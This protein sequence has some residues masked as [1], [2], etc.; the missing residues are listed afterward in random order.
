MTNNMIGWVAGPTERGTLMLVWSCLITIFACTWT[1]LR[2]RVF[3]KIK[4]MG[5]NILF[6]EF[7]LYKDVCDLRLA[8]QELGEFREKLQ[9]IN[10]SIAWNEAVS[11]NG[12][13]WWWEW[14]LAPLPPLLNF[15]WHFSS[16]LSGLLQRLRFGYPKMRRNVSDSDVEMRPRVLSQNQARER[17]HLPPDSHFISQDR[18]HSDEE[19][20]PYLGLNADDPVF[21]RASR[22]P[23]HVTQQ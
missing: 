14:E 13:G 19:S 15:L 10:K 11:G 3:R 16:G 1:V 18:E 9:T 2:K 12:E 6:P 4:W 22:T 17:G 5:I 8:V 20:H 7:I 21:R 23:M